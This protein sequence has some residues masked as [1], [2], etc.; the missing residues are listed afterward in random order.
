M[1]I[2]NLRKL[3]FKV[4][5]FYPIRRLFLFIGNYINFNIFIKHPFVNRKFF[6]KLWDHKTYWF[7]KSKTHIDEVKFLN[8]LIKK[9]DTCLEVGAH[10]GYLSQIIENIIG[11]DGKLFVIEPSKKNC[12]YLRKNIS[13]NSSLFQLAFSNFVGQSDLYLDNSGGST[14][15]LNYDF[16]SKF[17]KNQA[18]WQSKK[19]KDIKSEKVEINTLDNFCMEKNFLPKFIK[20]DTEGNEYK[21]LEKSKNI[22][23]YTNSIMMEIT[24]GIRMKSIYN[25]M[26]SFDFAAYL[27]NKTL[28]LKNEYPSGNIFFVKKNIQIL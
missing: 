3:I 9:G 22:L 14:N 19:I 2:F 17:E 27:P 12:S 6:L 4:V 7:I 26:Y 15:T 16:L 21:I 11:R 25:L 10:I 23:P 20:I 8:L 18:Y 5:K 24:Y 28:I 1:K 13:K